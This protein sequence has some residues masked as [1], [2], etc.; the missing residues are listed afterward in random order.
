[1]NCRYLRVRCSIVAANVADSHK[2]MGYY[3][4]LGLQDSALSEVLQ[5]GAAPADCLPG[6]DI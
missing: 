3:A 2:P 5:Q 4:E 6:V 1:M